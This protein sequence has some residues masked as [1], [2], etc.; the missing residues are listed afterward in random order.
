MRKKVNEPEAVKIAPVRHARFYSRPGLEPVAYLCDGVIRIDRK[1][2]ESLE[3]LRSRCRSE[4]TW[5]DANTVHI[6]TP[7]HK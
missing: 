2:N 3:E 6:F 7:F 4:V 5:P 1:R